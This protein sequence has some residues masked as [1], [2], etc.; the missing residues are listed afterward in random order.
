MAAVVFDVVIVIVAGFLDAV[1][2]TYLSA[3]YV[4]FMSGNSTGLAIAIAHGRTSFIVAS[5]AVIAG[6]VIGAFAGSL[7]VVARKEAA[8]SI[9]LAIEAGLIAIAAMLVGHVEQVVSLLPV[10]IAMGMQNAIPRQID[11]V[12][13]GRSFV[14]GALFGMAKALAMSVTDR[15]H[16]LQAAALG[17][18]WVALVGGAIGGSLSLAAFGLPLC[19]VAAAIALLVILAG[20]LLYR[21]Q[22]SGPIIRP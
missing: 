1:G 19:L 5:A 17:G 16:L 20:Y 11:G 9:V 13:G 14:T 7:L 18:T 21:G 22:P 4:S 8:T 3:L 6:F 10:C 2:F 12:A 15:T